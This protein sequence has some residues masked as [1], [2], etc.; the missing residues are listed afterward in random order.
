LPDVTLVAVDTFPERL[1]PALA[2]STKDIA[3]G[4]VRVFNDVAIHSMED[5]SQWV[6]TQLYKEVPTSHLLIVQWDGYVRNWRAWTDAWLRYDYIGAPWAHKDGMNVGN[7]GFSLRSRRLMELVATDSAIT[8]YHPEDIRICRHYRPHLEAAH[9]IRF[10]PEDVAR[11][12]SI[13]GY[14][15]ANRTH[16]T[17]FGFHGRRVKFADARPPR[18]PRGRASRALRRLFR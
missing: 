3:F 11:L 9:D 17:E 7:G 8:A 5:Y 4:A 15:Q 13:E 10:A 2:A 16:T 1:A 6:C 12:F 14:G 18:A